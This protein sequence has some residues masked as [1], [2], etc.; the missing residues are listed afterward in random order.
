MSSGQLRSG[1]LAGL[2]IMVMICSVPA[3]AN[4]SRSSTDVAAAIQARLTHAGYLTFPMTKDFFPTGHAP[5]KAFYV[6]V[7]EASGHAFQFG[8]C[9]FPTAVAATAN[10]TVYLKQFHAFAKPG[11]YAIVRAGRII[12]Q[13][14]TGTVNAKPPPMLPTSKFRTVLALAEGH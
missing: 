9:V 6:I 10:Y 1:L 13:G 3:V 8:V 5:Q 14:T 11:A 4:T 7:D 12:F 2:A